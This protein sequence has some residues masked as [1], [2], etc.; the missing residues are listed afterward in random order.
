MFGKT[1]VLVDTLKDIKVDYANFDLINIG[2]SKI[3]CETNFKEIILKNYIDKYFNLYRKKFS[4]QLYEQITKKF[5]GAPIDFNFFEF[6]NFRNDK[7]STFEKLILLSI[8]KNEINLNSYDKIVIY[9]DEN[10]YFSLYS[11]FV[12][13]KLY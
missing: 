11:N 13:K 1:L 3:I 7:D 12:K 2:N 4:I 8:I 9:Y 6:C 10:K 5:R